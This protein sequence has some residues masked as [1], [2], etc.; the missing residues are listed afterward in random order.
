MTQTFVAKIDCGKEMG[1]AGAQEEPI[2][3][4]LDTEARNTP[5]SDDLKAPQVKARV[6]DAFEKVAPSRRK[7]F[8]RLVEDVKTRET[9]ERRI[10]KVVAARS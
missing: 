6:L 9:R 2:R 1:V 8:G 10:L 4:A 3:L 5:P 7:K